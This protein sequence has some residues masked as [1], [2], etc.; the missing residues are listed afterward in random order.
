MLHVYRQVV[1][2]FQIVPVWWRGACS[3][4]FYYAQQNSSV[5]VDQ[6]RWEPKQ[7]MPRGIKHSRACECACGVPYIHCV[8]VCH[9][10]FSCN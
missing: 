3:R 8:C 10:F 6:A 1:F 9:H 2:V 4:L 5:N 7:N